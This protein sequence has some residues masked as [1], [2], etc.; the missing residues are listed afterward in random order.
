M[1]F[2]SYDSKRTLRSAASFNR[3]ESMCAAMILL[4]F[5]SADHTNFTQSC[6]HT[7]RQINHDVFSAISSTDRHQRS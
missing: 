1:C 2:H 3:R 7:T 4:P 6:M 5:I